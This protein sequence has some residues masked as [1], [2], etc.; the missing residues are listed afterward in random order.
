MAAY[1]IIAPA[2][3]ST[4]LARFDG[5]R[6][7]VRSKEAKTLRDVYELVRKMVLVLK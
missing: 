2:E 5:I 7:G 3:A 1:Y 4:N 6:Y